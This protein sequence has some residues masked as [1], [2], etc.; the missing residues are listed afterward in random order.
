MEFTEYLIAGMS[1]FL[2][3][4]PEA[5]AAYV[6]YQRLL[7]DPV[8]WEK[9]EARE[10][11]LTDQ[12]LIIGDASEESIVKLVRVMQQRGAP[13]AEITELTGLSPAEVERLG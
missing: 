7:D 13:V 10:Q 11:F 12:W 5:L 8:L 2:D 6:A 4:N 1:T 9:I 3:D